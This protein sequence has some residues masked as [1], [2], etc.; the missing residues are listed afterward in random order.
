MKSCIGAEG[1]LKN[2]LDAFFAAEGIEL[3]VFSPKDADVLVQASPERAESRIHAIYAG[4]WVRCS[5]ARSLADRLGLS[6]RE[7]GKLL[8]H[9][10]VKIKD[11]ELGCF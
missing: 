4:G 6:R 5:T 3:R 8:D 11:C 7:M 10:E 2:K 9:L 1:D